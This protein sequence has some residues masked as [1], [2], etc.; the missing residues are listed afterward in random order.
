MDKLKQLVSSKRKALNEEF[1]GKKYVK[2][3]ELEEARVKK[4]R[5]EEEEER[6][7]KVRRRKL[8]KGKNNAWC[9]YDVL[10]LQEQSRGQ[11]NSSNNAVKQSEKGKVEEEKKLP[12]EIAKLAPDEVIRRLRLLKQPIK[13]F[14][15]TVE[16]RYRRLLEAE[17]SLEVADEAE[18]GQQANLHTALQR[19]EKERAK[20]MESGDRTIVIFQGHTKEE[21]E[22]MSSFQEAAAA[23]AEKT[24]SV[25]DAIEKRIRKWMLDWENELEDRSMED[26]LSASGRQADVRFKETQEYLRPL[27]YRLKHRTLDPQLL[28]GIKIIVDSMKERN[29]LHA[30]RIYMGVAIGNSPWPIGVTQVGLHER[31]SRE[32]ISFKYASGNAHI[33]ND[34]ATRKLIQ[35]LKR[36]MTFCQRKYPTDPSRCVDFDGASNSVGDKASDKISLLNAVARGE[37]IN[38]DSTPTLFKDNGAKIPEKWDAILRNELQRIQTQD[39][40]EAA[41]ER[42]NKHS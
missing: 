19:Q 11:N 1:G 21:L 20:K 7:R 15:E 26:K 24:M 14:G 6:R 2:R 4:L 41:E 28:A 39:E 30:Y 37:N 3:A 29:Y 31:A 32:K 34:E 10:I 22:L 42:Q 27:Y 9:P 12:E 18:G 13:L 35:A 23:I 5:A 25:E 36:L 33:M 16:A 40:K 8:N 38:S 17:S